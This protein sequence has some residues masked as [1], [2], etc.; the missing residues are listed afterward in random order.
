MWSTKIVESSDPD[1]FVSLIRPADRKLLVTER[2]QFA[3]RATLID[4]GGLQA[5][6]RYERLARV[7]HIEAARPGIIFLTEPGPEMFLNG[8]AIRHG[9]IAVFNSGEAYHWRLSGSTRWGAMTLANDDMEDVGRSYPGGRSMRMNGF[10]VVTPPA[11]AL[12]RLR[13]LHASAGDLA[14]ASEGSIEQSEC[15]Q[16][17]EQALIM[18]MMESIGTADVR[19]DTM[20]RQHHQMVIQRFFQALQAQALQP[21]SMQTIS[22]AIGVSSRTLRIACHQ[23]FGIG[24]AQYIMLRR[25]RSARRALRK[26]N[27][28]TTRVTDI[29]TEH[30]FW[31]LGR[32]AV[33]YR[34]LFGES[35]SATLRA[36]A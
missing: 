8:A 2:G 17:V 24:P 29:A 22:D 12:A 26:A 27:P 16:M 34:Y 18:A 5:Q 31:E 30:G 3:A 6:R 4:I 7:M 21:F 14:P 33:K 28:E 25:M 13:G 19:P 23:Q 35:P 9:D 20:A 36:A 10:S 11:G 1:E 32:F 15:A